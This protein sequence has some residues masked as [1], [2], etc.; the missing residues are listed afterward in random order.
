MDTRNELDELQCH[1]KENQDRKLNDTD[2]DDDGVNNA[3]AHFTDCV[4]LH[5]CQNC[6]T[7]NQKSSAKVCLSC[8]NIGIV[9]CT[10]G[11]FLYKK[12]DESAIHQLLDGPLFSFGV[13][14]QE[15]ATS[16]TSILKEKRYATCHGQP[17]EGEVQ[18]EVTS[19]HPHQQAIWIGDGAMEFG[20]ARR[21]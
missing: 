6:S 1:I 20:L 15:K 14:H 12:E 3:T 9:Y 2:A 4:A 21:Q 13:R 11:H 5:N 19:T 18:E 17:I 8:W 16:R 7:R 10:C